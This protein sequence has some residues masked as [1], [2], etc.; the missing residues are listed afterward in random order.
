MQ[1][2]ANPEKTAQHQN[3][4]EQVAKTEQEI[5]SLTRDQ[6]N[7][8]QRNEQL[9]GKYCRVKKGIEN[10][11]K[12]REAASKTSP[13]GKSTDLKQQNAC[14]RSDIG[15][16]EQEIEQAKRELAKVKEQ[17]DKMTK[18]SAQKSSK[19]KRKQPYK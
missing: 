17:E 7:L 6:Q 14:L 13:N 16:V 10:E 15:C 18:M 5:A 9:E 2:T 3:I 12:R 19:G 1:G 8:L 11:K 4:S